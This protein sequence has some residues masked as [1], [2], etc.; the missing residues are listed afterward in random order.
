M[1]PRN[2]VS[3]VLVL[4]FA[5]AGCS[6]DAGKDIRIEGP[7]DLVG[8]KCAVVVGSMMGDMTQK[9]QPG[10]EVEWFNDYNSGVEAVRIGKIAAMPLDF[11]YARRWA[12]QNPGEF[13]ITKP[14]HSIPW[15]YFFAKGNPLRDKVNGV[16]RRMKA[17]GDLDRILKRWTEA[18]DPGAL[19]PEIPAYRKDF[20]GKAGTLRFAMPGD[21]EPVCFVCPD[22]IV[23]FDIDI[24]RRIAYELDMKFELVQ[25]TM[26]A[27]VAAVE[28]GKVDMG[29]GGMAI[30][31]ERAEKVDFSECYYRVPTVF[32]VRAASVGGKSR[33]EIRTLADLKGCTCATL[34]GTVLQDI[35]EREQDGINYQTYNDLP[36]AIEAICLG[37]VD[38]MPMDT[39]IARR[40]AKERSD[41]LRIF[42]TFSK[43]PYGYFLAKGSPLID[44]VN[45]V[46]KAL[47]AS[48]EIDR[49]IDKWCDAAD[50]KTVEFEPRRK[51]FTGKGGV[52]RF[53]TTGEYE[54]GSFVRDGTIAGFDIDILQ[55]IADE[56][57]ME[58]KLVMVTMNALVPTV[59]G[60]KADI[61]GGCVTITES[62][63]EKVDF[64]DCYLDGGFAIIG[65][66]EKA[67]GSGIR[68]AADLKGKHVA[69]LSSDFHKK[70]L[71]ALEPGITF[72][73][74]SE[75]AFAVES[76]RKGKI[77]A[78]SLGRT[79]ADIWMT[80]FP[81]EFRVAFEYADDVVAFL[82]PK[83]SSL[84]QKFDAELRKMNAAGETAA[85]IRKWM[86][87]AKSGTPP[88]MPKFP[89]APK[90]AQEIRVACAA[91]AE[92]WCFA[93][94]DGL[95]GA[96]IEILFT[97]AQRL[98]WNLKPK[99][100]SWGGMVDCVN[101]GRCEI[102]CGGIYT[103][104]RT[105]P[106]V[107]ASEKYTDERMCLLV[108]NEG[109]KGGDSGL[110]AFAK[111]LKESFIRTFVTES[112]WKM[113]AN[114]FGITLLITFLAALFG[115]ALAFPVWLAR[116]SRIGI[117]SSCARGYIAILQGTPVLVLLMIL[118]YIVFGK[119]DIDG[120]WV[121]VI[122]FGL[123][124]SAYAGEMLRSGVESVPRGQTEAALA[125]GYTKWQS[126]FRFVLPQAVR[127]IL[128]VYRGELIG[129]LK[130]TS[131]VGYIAIGDL[132][133]A[134]DLVRSRTYESFFPII[135]TAFIYFVASW[136][137]A[138]ALERVGRRLDPAFARNRKGANA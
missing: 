86:D 102:A 112:R 136:L 72:D 121:A 57:D 111:S 2:I 74:Y 51:G 83:N 59:Q 29:G 27:M 12:I 77:D 17:S 37:K 108:R 15:G 16:L 38:A 92:P 137:L 131:I 67:S 69:H 82:L 94:D 120:I 128:P 124:L 97:L 8:R 50:L 66:R 32:R 134:S 119:V 48:G 65:R 3:A 44:R 7:K 21:R 61:G 105:F 85:I 117:V 1:N 114:G 91:Q 23:G 4:A 78:I 133:K 126:F 56:L 109:F 115:T 73:P 68:T 24:V 36:S 25:I 90:G 13:A 98:G 95:A 125:L 103:A 58:L 87:G 88:P 80:K 18:D 75:Y 55:R 130:M 123:N 113:L 54:P 122:G 99:I 34:L 62:R 33:A 104:G 11:F 40:W 42:L 79:Y 52:L 14:Y 63:K 116:T 20:T 100:F 96:D 10:I 46:I 107:D 93:A 28:S 5:A 81:G 106:T 31:A 135:T 30:T 45:S 138:F 132:T 41:D 71:L 43:N 70:E 89:A 129:L 101:A 60:G 47:K 118:F 53:A 127:A 35:L 39:V 84:K 49:I 110:A 64:T 76:L 26:G 6:R 22:G 9:V 19:K